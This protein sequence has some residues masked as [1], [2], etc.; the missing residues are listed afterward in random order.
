[1]YELQECSTKVSNILSTLTYYPALTN[2]IAN[3]ILSNSYLV[4]QSLAT[5]FTCRYR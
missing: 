2:D 4:G 1:M 5:Y 3:N